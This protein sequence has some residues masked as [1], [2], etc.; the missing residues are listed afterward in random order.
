MLDPTA[1]LADALGRKLSATYLRVFGG[2]APHYASLLDEASRLVIE[3]IAGSDALYHDAHHTALVTLVGQAMLRG[4]RLVREVT[5]EDWLHF[6]LAALTHDIGFVRGACRGDG[7]EGYIVD[8]AGNRVTPP[9]GASD[10]FFAPYHVER[11]KIAVRERFAESMEVDAERIA[12][13]IELTRFPVPDDD[14]YKETDTEAG[15]LRA[16][17]L[18]GQLG[19]PLYLRKLTAL[20]HEFEEIGI[21]ASL[22]YQNPADL[23]EQY[24]SFFWRRVEPYIRDGLRYLDL[25]T[26][27]RIW[28]SN[29]YSHV[30][31]IEHGR[32]HLGPHSGQRM[33]APTPANAAIGETDRTPSA[34]PADPS[35]GKRLGKLS[36]LPGT[37]A[38]K[39]RT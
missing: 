12:R 24:P 15:L 26:D 28:V 25:T 9:R 13:A 1:L 35:P 23:V 2:R 37:A 7:P 18:V 33:V 34:P 6:I 19:D 39:I 3:R 30:F 36:D 31:A 5:P 4:R 38:G 32:R 21:A 10:A 22:G 17:D 27:G 29:L 16:A 20:F 11:S 14:D 8:T